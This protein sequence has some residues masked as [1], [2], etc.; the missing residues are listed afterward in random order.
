MD[1]N[2]NNNNNLKKKDQSPSTNCM[3]T[4]SVTIKLHNCLNY[5]FNKKNCLNISNLT[6]KSKRE[7]VKLKSKENILN[8]VF[9][10]YIIQKLIV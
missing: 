6:G 5:S 10:L 9:Q 7:Y 1:L 2:N 3:G 8:Y 4:S